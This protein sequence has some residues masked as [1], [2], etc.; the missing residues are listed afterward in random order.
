MARR[1]HSLVCADTVYL[2]FR[3]RLESWSV[4]RCTVHHARDKKVQLAAGWPVEGGSF[5]HTKYLMF[6]LLPIIAT[7]ITDVFLKSTSP[8]YV[9][10]AWFET[11]PRKCD[12]K[13]SR[14]PSK[15]LVKDISATWVTFFIS[16]KVVDCTF[17]LSSP[18]RPNPK[19]TE[20]PCYRAAY[21]LH[22]TT[23]S[24]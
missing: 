18:S 2:N 11:V 13:S 8:S 21:L 19:K 24:S 10:V 14:H 7:L 20:F 6:F 22:T 3:A 12:W 9:F 17:W 1:V 5:S 4:L 15:A 23:R 16:K